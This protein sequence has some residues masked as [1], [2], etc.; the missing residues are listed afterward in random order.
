M[1]LKRYNLEEPE[2]QKIRNPKQIQMLKIPNS[3]P[4]ADALRCCDAERPVSKC[5]G[6]PRL[7][8]SGGGA[9]ITSSK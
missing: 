4:E 7:S 2:I 3:P 9:K 6:T 1:G 8:A 5:I